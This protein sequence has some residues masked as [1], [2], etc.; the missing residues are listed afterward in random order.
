MDYWTVYLG[1][2]W[3]SESDKGIFG[4]HKGTMTNTPCA[5]DIPCPEWSFDQP[6]INHLKKEDREYSY[7]FYKFDEV[8]ECNYRGAT[9]SDINCHHKKH[10]KAGNK[11]LNYYESI[12]DS[13]SYFRKEI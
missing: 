3:S 13:I 10:K 9:K 1:P 5:F 2:F 8:D 11:K 12:Y 7:R 6:Q 4:V